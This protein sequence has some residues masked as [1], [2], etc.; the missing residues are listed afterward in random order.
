M[1]VTRGIYRHFKGKDYFVHGVVMNV[2][3]DPPIECVLYEALQSDPGRQ[4]V[5][6]VKNFT[7]TVE[8]SGYA[9]PRFYRKY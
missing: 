8:T 9:G 7:E 6:S 3:A 4:F 1:T 2:E 5:R